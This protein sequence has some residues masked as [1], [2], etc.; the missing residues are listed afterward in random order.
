M[1]SHIS[2]LWWIKPCMTH[3]NEQTK[4]RFFFSFIAIVHE[5]WHYWLHKE[6]LMN[7]L[8][9]Q[10]CA[11]VIAGFVSVDGFNNKLLA[12][13]AFMLKTKGMWDETFVS[14][15]EK[16]TPF[17]FKNVFLL[18]HTS[19]LPMPSICGTLGKL[20][21]LVRCW[22]VFRNHDIEPP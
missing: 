20:K 22:N 16:T 2:Q 10:W 17:L 11:L 13:S 1:S 9:C 19:R 7:T 12:D 8:T 6:E 5:L 14:K 21:F 18:L 15:N 3:K 4:S